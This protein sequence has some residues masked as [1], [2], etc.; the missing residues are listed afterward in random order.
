MTLQLIGNDGLSQSIDERTQSQ[1]LG[2]VTDSNLESK[3]APSPIFF[4]PSWKVTD[5]ILLQKLKAN[6]LI[7][8]SDDGKM[9]FVKLEQ[10][11]KALLIIKTPSENSTDFKL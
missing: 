6:S 1:V 7:I 10:K 2:S 4:I 9:I 11:L 5:A 8:V 3:K